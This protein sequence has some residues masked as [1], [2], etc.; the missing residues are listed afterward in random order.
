MAAQLIPHHHN[1]ARTHARAFD[2]RLVLD[3]IYIC[4][5]GTNFIVRGDGC[6]IRVH[7]SEELTVG[8]PV[9]IQDEGTTGMI[10]EE[11]SRGPQRRRGNGAV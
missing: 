7:R 1:A 11:E 6:K 8:A 4:H 2:T 10:L 5:K 3:T 9:N